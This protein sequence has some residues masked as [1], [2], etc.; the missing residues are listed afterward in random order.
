MFIEPTIIRVPLGFSGYTWL[1]TEIV[2][3][4]IKNKNEIFLQNLKKIDY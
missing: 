1:D 2:L 3:K 4:K